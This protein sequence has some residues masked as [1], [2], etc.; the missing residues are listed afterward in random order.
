MTPRRARCALLLALLCAAPAGSAVA[1]GA[2]PA[3]SAVASGAA[4]AG[5]AVASGAAPSAAAPHPVPPGAKPLQAVRGDHVRIEGKLYS[6]QAVF[7]MSRRDETFRRDAIVPHYLA[8]PSG[9]AFLPYTLRAGVMPAP[10]TAPR[11]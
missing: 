5:S 1:S 10:A 3:G 11:P 8:A 7:V 9:T 2:V 6:P 4:P